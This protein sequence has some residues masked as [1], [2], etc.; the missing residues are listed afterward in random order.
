MSLVESKYTVMRAKLIPLVGVLSFLFSLAMLSITDKTLAQNSFLTDSEAAKYYSNPNGYVNNLVDF[1]GKVLTFPESD[2][3]GVY[4]LQMYQGGDRDR[5]TIVFYTSPIQLSKDDCVRVVG[6][7]QQDTLYKNMFGAT[8]TAATINADSVT[9]I[10]CYEDNNPA[11]NVV[12]VEK[13]QKYGGITVTLHKVEFS[14]KNTRVYLTLGNSDPSQDV[15]FYDS[16]AKAVQGHTQFQTVYSFEPT[17]P[18]IEST[19]PPGISENGVVLFEPL[20]KTQCGAQFVFDAQKGDDDIKFTFDVAF[21]SASCVISESIKDADK[22]LAI[23]ST[24][25]ALTINST[26]INT[27]ISK[28]YALSG[29]DKPNEA[30]RYYDI[31]LVMNSTDLRALKSKGGDLLRLGNYTEAIGVSDTIL[32]IRP[33]DTYALNLKALAQKNEK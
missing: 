1:K 6:T 12:V 13:I 9:K 5:N 21:L 3:G 23:N 7:A 18:K 2:I 32:E 20:D 14:D 11:K 33:N 24:D 8:R 25:K 17:Y 28:G 10:D 16:N 26:D 4:A 15:T 31:A 27:L 30:I 19:I 29:L 22:A